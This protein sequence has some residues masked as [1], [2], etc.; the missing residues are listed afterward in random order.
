MVQ[1]QCASYIYEEGR[2]PTVIPK[3]KQTTSTKARLEI[4]RRI[5]NS[6]VVIP[7][8]SVCRMHQFS[9][10]KTSSIEQLLFFVATTGARHMKRLYT[11]VDRLLKV[12]KTQELYACNTDRETRRNNEEHTSLSKKKSEKNIPGM[13]RRSWGQQAS[14]RQK[15]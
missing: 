8:P 10:G 2:T 11:S 1:Q 9:K 7:T 3:S 12:W 14:R 5:R 4:Y 6:E 13:S 15:Q